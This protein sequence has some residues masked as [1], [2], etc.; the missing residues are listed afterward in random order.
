MQKEAATFSVP[1]LQVLDEHGALDRK[2]DPRMPDDKA[3]ELYKWMVYAR[4]ADDRML[5]LQRQGRLGTFP[6]CIGQEAAH[7]A[8]AL[9]MRESDWFAGAFREAGARMMRGEPYR[10]LLLYYN[11]WE[12]GN[13]NPASPRTLPIYVI[14]A[15]QLLHAT[16]IAYAMRYKGE[17]DT[18]A[19][20]FIGDGGTSEGDFHE[21]LNFASVWKVPVIFIVQ[22]NQWAISVPL[23]K[24]TAS[25][26]IAQKAIAYDVP[27]IQVDGNDPLAM[28]KVTNEALERG[29]KGEGP[30]L[31]EAVT[32]R[33][34][35]HTTAD[36]DTKYRPKEEVEPWWKRDPLIRFKAYLESKKLWDDSKETKLWE[37]AKAYVSAEV[38]EFERVQKSGEFKPDEPFKHLYGTQHTVIEQQHAEFRRLN[39]L[40]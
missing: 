15:S 1:Y 27:G 38:E 18:C 14:I 24:Q 10:N 8:P 26:T 40:S 33:L 31:I 11:G 5:K 32:Y 3:L 39:G 20:A 28:W 23:K 17:K 7:C 29:R 30:T 9:A 6:P 22:N 37:E 16:G 34:K 25:R 19:V 2:F 21:A 36:D 12:E 4:E 13:V 35:M